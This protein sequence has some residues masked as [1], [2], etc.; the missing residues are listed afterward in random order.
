MSSVRLLPPLA[1]CFF[2]F[3]GQAALAQEAPIPG[4][5]VLRPVATAGEVTALDVRMTIGDASQPDCAGR[6]F[7][8]VAP[9]VYAGVAGIADRMQGITLEDRAGP[10]TLAIRDDPPAPGGFPYFRNFTAE[11]AIAC[12]FTLR[13]TAKVQPPGGRNGPPFGIRAVGGGLAGAGSGFMLVPGLDRDVAASVQWDLAGLGENAS[14]ASTFGDGDFV[15]RGP[16]AGLMQGWYIAGPLGR[17]PEG[18]PQPGGLHAYWLGKP[19]FD[20]P[21]DMAWTASAYAYL[22][23]YFGYLEQPEYRVFMRFLEQP[24]FGGAT[25]LDNSF[26]LSRGPLKPDEAPQAPRSTLFHEMI[27]QWVGGIDAPQGVS[28]WFSEGL[29]TYY[30]YILPFRGGFIG[31]EAYRDGVN[32]LARDYF[33]NPARGMSAA[34]I[35][36]IGFG[37]DR[38]RHMPYQRGAFYFADLDSRIRART[39]GKSKLEDLLFRLFRDRQSGKTIDHRYWTDAVSEILGNDERERFERIILKGEEMAAPASD[40]F[41]PCLEAIATEFESDGKPRPGYVWKIRELI[42]PAGCQSW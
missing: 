37:D 31:L 11:R 18:R 2:A 5:V 6:E 10:V 27:H 24:P 1:A 33:T 8:L 14:A 9:V 3:A 25:A 20:A 36:R 7:G 29:T 38:I 39:D 22:K 42:D 12:P 19:V 28:S 21:R 13:Y 15:Y 16:I 30:E 34:D 17:F 35:T 26:M 4:R 32:K 41:G 23:Q 40:G